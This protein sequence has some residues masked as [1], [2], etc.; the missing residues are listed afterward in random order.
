M[1][2]PL[3]SLAT[4]CEARPYTVIAIILAVTILFSTG[5]PLIEQD[6]DMES[7]LP[8]DN[9]ALQAT[10]TLYDI[11]GSQSY[12]NIL[13]R[14]DVTSLEGI[15]TILELQETIAN[16][17]SFE[18]YVLSVTTYVDYL[19]SAGLI[20]SDIDET[21][22]AT[23]QQILAADAASDSPQ[24]IGRVVSVDMQNTLVTVQI[25]GDYNDEGV[26]DNI[27]RLMGMVSEFSEADNGFT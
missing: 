1:K 22:A 7:Y 26:S 9:E 24:F 6:V 21:T 2:N 17:P 4:V 20:S 5:I 27:E 3:K 12:E 14:G 15:L 11:Y 19:V 23:I 10:M 8:E 13:V 16:E 18:D 25:E